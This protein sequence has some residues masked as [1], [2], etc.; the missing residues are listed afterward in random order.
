MIIVF[1][2]EKGNDVKEVIDKSSLYG[3][4]WNNPKEAIKWWE[5]FC[6][7]NCA[8]WLSPTEE[9]I[10]EFYEFVREKNHD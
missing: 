3:V 1:N 5:R 2:K 4:F 9:T 7:H 6:E 8:S 10:K